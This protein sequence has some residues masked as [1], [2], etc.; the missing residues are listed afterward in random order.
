MIT[1]PSVST[2]LVVVLA[3]VRNGVSMR[4]IAAVSLIFLGVSTLPV[5]AQ[6]FSVGPGGVRVDPGYG[7]DRD[8]DGRDRGYRRDDDDRRA[9]MERRR[10]EERERYRRHRDDDD[11]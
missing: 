11:R 8:D 1:R 3:I 5:V 2:V 6:G 9:Q 7:R 10:Y 4:R